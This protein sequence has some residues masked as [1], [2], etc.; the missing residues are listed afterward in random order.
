MQ[1]AISLGTRCPQ[2]VHFA[3]ASPVNSSTSSPHWGHFFIVMETSLP[4]HTI[5]IYLTLS[6]WNRC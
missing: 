4:G 2:F 1:A 5:D 3:F 6:F